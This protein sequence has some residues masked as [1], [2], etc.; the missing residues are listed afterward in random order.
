MIVLLFSLI[1]SFNYDQV[2][3]SSPYPWTV[4]ICALSSPVN[5]WEMYDSLYEKTEQPL[6]PF[7]VPGLLETKRIWRCCLGGYSSAEEADVMVQYLK[8]NGF[9]ALAKKMQGIILGSTGEI[10]ISDD[11]IRLQTGEIFPT[12]DR[13]QGYYNHHRA[14]LSPDMQWAALIFSSG[15]GFENEGESMVLAR[16]SDGEERLVLISSEMINPLIWNMESD[17]PE[18]IV[19]TQCGGVGYGEIFLIEVETGLITWQDKNISVYEVCENFVKYYLIDPHTE[20]P[21][22]ST[23]IGF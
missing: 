20:M 6:F 13:M 1:F 22:D 18:I 9:T 3:P 2:L 12:D 5:T 15:I 23:G 4:Q 10:D 17:K 11:E 21:L 7:Q 19:S 16:I 8:N 14:Y